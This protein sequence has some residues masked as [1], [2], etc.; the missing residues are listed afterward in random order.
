MHCSYALVTVLQNQLT[1]T[2]AVFQ[3]NV[4]T[5]YHILME[6]NWRVLS[7]HDFSVNC[8][9]IKTK[10]LKRCLVRTVPTRK[11]DHIPGEP[12]GYSLPSLTPA[13]WP[14]VDFS[15]VATLSNTNIQRKLYFIRFYGK[16]RQTGNKT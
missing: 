15:D 1:A 2:L 5:R 16:Q 8:R 6:E 10:K 9:S 11:L 4:K 14:S 13:Y 7:M 3:L 12:H